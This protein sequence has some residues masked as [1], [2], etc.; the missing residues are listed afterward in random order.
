LKKHII[1]SENSHKFLVIQK[2][3]ST[4]AAQSE[5][6]QQINNKQDEKNIPAPQP[7]ES[8]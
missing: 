5:K 6:Y 7:Q 8:Q 3:M 4:F 1:I 2:E